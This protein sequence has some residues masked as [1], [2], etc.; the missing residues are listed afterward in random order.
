MY[1]IILLALEV[2]MC[3]S[4]ALSILTRPIHFS[5]KLIDPQTRLLSKLVC[6][7]NL[8]TPQHNLQFNYLIGLIQITTK[9]QHPA[10]MTILRVTT[11]AHT[12]ADPALGP[13][14]LLPGFDQEA[15][16]AIVARLAVW[17]AER[18]DHDSLR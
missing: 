10:G 16:A 4:Y 8:F 14:A 18:E 5:L 9:Y 6:Y 13:R 15:A 1:Q 11:I 17:K 12:F 3:G 2:L 7:I